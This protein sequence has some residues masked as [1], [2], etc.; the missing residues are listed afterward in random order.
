MVT[1]RDYFALR[2]LENNSLIGSLSQ[3]VDRCGCTS[4]NNLCGAIGSQ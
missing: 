1:E 4:R 3:V 2:I